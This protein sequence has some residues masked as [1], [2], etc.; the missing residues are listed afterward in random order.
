MTVSDLIDTL[1]QRAIREA[2]GASRTAPS[3]WK[4]DGIIPPRY[5]PIFE[6][7]CARARIRCERRFFAF[8]EPAEPAEAPKP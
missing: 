3:N 5:F 4:T 2:T 7:M 8:A 1:G 6:E